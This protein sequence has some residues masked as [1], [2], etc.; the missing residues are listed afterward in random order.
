MY[1]RILHLNQKQSAFIF[2]PRGTGKTSFLKTTYRDAIYFDLLH[3][4]TYTE[5]LGNPSLLESRI[6]S[7]YHDWVIIDK[8]QK[9]PSLLNE[10]HRLIEK[11][12][13]RF[14]LTGS[15]ARSLR[16]KGVN[17]LAG[18]AL[19]N[20]MHTLL[21]SEIGEE[22]DLPR[23]L[24]TGL[25]P[26][27]YQSMHPQEYLSAYVDTYLKEE[28]LQEALTRNIQLF[29][30]FLATASFSQGNVLNYT[31]IAREIGTTRQTVTHFFNILEDLL[32]AVQLPVFSKRAK[33]EVI[34]QNK[35][36]YFDAGIYLT[37]R[38]KGPLDSPEELRG[39][40]LETLFLQHLSALNDY[41]HLNYEISFW[42]TRSQLEVDFILYGERGLFAF[43][44][45][46][47]ARLISK[48]FKGLKTF[49]A[50]YPMAKC[51]LIYQGDARYYDED[52]QIL[53]AR[54]ALFELSAILSG[55]S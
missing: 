35:F 8:I 15:S 7:H 23:A 39:P 31:E 34:A 43:E 46:S 45:K 55:Q 5:F 44:I 54:Q 19:T 38:P 12:R 4:Q 48:D 1:S 28:V 30:R 47:S 16:K 22:F 17:L 51:Y 20:H 53:P 24:T 50:D 10:V 36:Y 33:R 2:G 40:A 49:K 6:P 11:R 14:I 26:M 41:L 32:I 42:R 9:I 27:A 25:L 21:A 29:A 52:I 18:R 3:S 13:I 37:L